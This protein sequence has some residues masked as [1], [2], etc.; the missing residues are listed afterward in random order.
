MAHFECLLL[1]LHKL[2]FQL[3]KAKRK[4]LSSPLRTICLGLE[5]ESVYQVAM[6]SLVAFTHTGIGY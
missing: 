3:R 6:C 2:H 5:I 1:R 4:D